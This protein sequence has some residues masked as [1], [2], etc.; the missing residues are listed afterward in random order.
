MLEA[1]KQ[2]AAVKREKQNARQAVIYA[3]SEC[4]QAERQRKNQEA[5]KHSMVTIAEI[6]ATIAAA[7]ETNGIEMREQRVKN[8]ET[9]ADV[10]QK[11]L[12]RLQ[13]IAENVKQE[14]ALS[15]Q[16]LR[17]KM[18]HT[19]KQRSEAQKQI[20]EIP[21]CSGLVLYSKYTRAQTF[22]NRLQEYI[23]KCEEKKYTKALTFFSLFFRSTLPT[24]PRSSTNSS[25]LPW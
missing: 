24:A 15:A 11:D 22:Q 20:L 9:I 16:R 18:E 1:S 4:D 10:A 21:I 7:K 3:V 12:E 13:K 19:M 8:T 17:E 25:R 6:F 5:T 23:A 14:S 2:V